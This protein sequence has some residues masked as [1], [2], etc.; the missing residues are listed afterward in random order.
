MKKFEYSAFLKVIERFKI[1]NLQVAPP[2]IVMLGRRPETKNYDLSSL[3][4]V[5]CGAA[6]LAKDLQNEVSQWFKLS[7]TQ[8]WGMTETMCAALHVPG[9]ALDDSG[10][11]GYLDPNTEAKLVDDDGREVTEVGMP[12]E[13][14][15]RDPQM[16]MGYWRNEK[17]T[18]ETLDGERWLRTGD[19][20]KVD[21]KGWFWIVDRKKVRRGFVHFLKRVSRFVWPAFHP[22]S[23]I[24]PVFRGVDFELQYLP[25]EH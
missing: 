21:E 11:V 7:I 4:Y 25:S 16:C 24:A 6:P 23:G 10:G 12:G 3:K 20:A 18:A 5:M 17:A 1:T 19:V 8:G 2:I 22:V 13:L 9:G 14:Y 15:V